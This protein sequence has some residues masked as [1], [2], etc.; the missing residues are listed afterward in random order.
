[1]VTQEDEV[2]DYISVNDAAREM[3]MSPRTFKDKVL[4]DI[5]Y[6]QMTARKAVIRRADLDKWFSQRAA[7]AF[8]D[9]LVPETLTEIGLR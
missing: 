7:T 5:P 8:S 1:M 3:G 9:P 2:A 4:K 6:L